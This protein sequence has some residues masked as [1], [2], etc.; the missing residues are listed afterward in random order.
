MVDKSEVGNQV[1]VGKIR[2][3]LGTIS[4]EEVLRGFLQLTFQ[5]LY[6]YFI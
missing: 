6:L 1:P 3:Y 4:E 5:D 2:G